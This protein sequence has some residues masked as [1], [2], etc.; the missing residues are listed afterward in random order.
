MN[1]IEN[2]KPAIR[3]REC[4]GTPTWQR[5]RTPATDGRLATDS[6]SG[7]SARSEARARNAVIDEYARNVASVRAPGAAATEVHVEL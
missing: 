3:R 2:T 1:V 6:R 5:R 4:S 7:R